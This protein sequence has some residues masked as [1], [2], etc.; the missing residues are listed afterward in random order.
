MAT[1]R[2]AR[3]AATVSAI[4]VAALALTACAGGGGAAEPDKFTFLVNAENQNVVPSLEAMA[5]G[6]CKAEAE[7]LPLEVSTIP[8]A[9]LDQQLTLLA[10]QGELPVMFGAGGVPATSAT[11]AEQGKLVDFQEAL[12]EL[13]VIDLIEPAS[14]ST[15]ENLYGSFSVLPTELNI[16]GIFY[17]KAMFADAGLS[18]PATWDELMSA[19]ESFQAD[20]ITP[21]SASGSQGWPITRLVSGYLF[22]S[23]GPDAMSA[24]RD[25]DAKLTDPEY[26]AGAQAIADMGAAGMF[27]PNVTS[28]DYDSSINQFLTGEAAMMYMGTWALANVTNEEQAQIGV[29]NVGFMP[30]PAVEGGAGDISQ[31]I[32][33]VGL[34]MTLSADS[35]TPKVADWLKCFTQNFGATS[36]ET[37]GTI[38]GFKPQAEVELAPLTQDV[39]DRIAAADETVLWFEALFDQKTTQD[40]LANAALLVTG[41]LSPEE[42]MSLLQEDIDAAN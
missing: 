28:L 3:S 26:I 25:G 19:A 34:P 7:A 22:R 18:E 8:Q 2:R 23:L 36:F 29:E 33:N 21:F 31:Y 38:T 1:A 10:S 35:Y 27:G 39:M 16:E 42:F 41:D 17:N 30:F 9:N 5:E 15:I 11:L 37:K 4:A 20:G 6:A 32:A 40:S 12:T 14:I 24:I 13:G